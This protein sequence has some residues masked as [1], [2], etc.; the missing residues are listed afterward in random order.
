MTLTGDVASEIQKLRTEQ[1]LRNYPKVTSV[2]NQLRIGS[3]SAPLSSPQKT[4]PSPTSKPAAALAEQDRTLTQLVTA[5]LN[6]NRGDFSV[7]EKLRDDDE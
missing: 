7:L 5:S 4:T 1:L 3:T 2:T 6:T